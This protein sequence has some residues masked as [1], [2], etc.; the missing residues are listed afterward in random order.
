[1][2]QE[3]IELNEISR[4]VHYML[5]LHEKQVMKVNIRKIKRCGKNAM[6]DFENMID[7]ST[8]SSYEPITTVRKP[9]GYYQQNETFGV[10]KKIVV[11]Q[12]SVGMEGD[13]FEG[14]IYA[15]YNKHRWLKI[16]YWC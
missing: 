10:F 6:E 12:R 11:D 7:G 3:I 2:T 4:Q 8:V 14:Y 13:S 15:K 1:M 16:P 5:A 9:Y